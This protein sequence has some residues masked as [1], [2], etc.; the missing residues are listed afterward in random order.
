MLSKL[1]TATR[2]IEVCQLHTHH[3]RS[4]APG[5]LS[6]QQ[7]QLHP[8]HPAPQT[9]QKC[10]AGRTCVKDVEP[11]TLQLLLQEETSA[12]AKASS[13]VHTCTRCARSAALGASWPDL[14]PQCVPATASHRSVSHSAR[15]E[16]SEIASRV[17]SYTSPPKNPAVKLGEIVLLK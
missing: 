3:T 10:D 6:S 4:Q 9:Q 15:Q 17:I 13:S 7:A 14:A 11:A 1:H 16:I 12:T 2:L 5:M 8:Q